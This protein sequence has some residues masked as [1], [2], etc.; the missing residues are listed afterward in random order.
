MLDDSMAVVNHFELDLNKH[1][2]TWNNPLLP[3]NLS[4][5]SSLEG[6]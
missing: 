1:V 4:L 6:I 5:L 3:K 2:L